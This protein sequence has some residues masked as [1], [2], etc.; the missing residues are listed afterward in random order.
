[1]SVNLHLS[2][3]VSDYDPTRA[4]AI[5][6]ALQA[7]V[8]SEGIAEDLPPLVETGDGSSRTLSSRSDPDFPVIVS[9]AYKWLP[10]VQA[11]LSEVANE[12]NGRPCKVVFDGE[13]A[14][15]DEDEPEDEVD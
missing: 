2:I 4:N 5:K 14:D 13:N 9:S 11:R 10:E 1:M 12:A 3:V 7:V 8:D 6:Q 15:E